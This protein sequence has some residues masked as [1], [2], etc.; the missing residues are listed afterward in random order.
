MHVWQTLLFKIIF[1]RHTA[2]LLFY[3]S[4]D[5]GHFCIVGQSVLTSIEALPRVYLQ[6]YCVRGFEKS[7][8][9]IT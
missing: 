6:N 3:H 7:V 9:V 5:D 2:I 1:Q 8:F 4:L